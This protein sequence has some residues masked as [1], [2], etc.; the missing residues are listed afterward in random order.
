MKKIVLLILSMVMSISLTSCSGGFGDL[1]DSLLN[2]N[3]LSYRLSDDGEGYIVTGIGDYKGEDIVIPE[4]Y[5]NLPVIAIGK[6]VGFLLNSYTASIENNPSVYNFSN[7]H[8][9]L[10]EYSIVNTNAENGFTHNH[11]IRSIKIPKTIKNIS[12][13]AFACCT[14]LAYIEVDEDNSAYK[15]I[16]GNL[17][18]KDGKTLVQYALGKNEKNFAIPEGV[19]NISNF[20]F[21]S[22]ADNSEYLTHTLG[23]M[24]TFE[25]DSYSYYSSFISGSLLVSSPIAFVNNCK[26]TSYTSPLESVNIPG[27][28]K[29]I[30]VQAFYNCANLL[31]VTIPNGV[32]TIGENAFSSCK[33]LESV[34]IPESVTT[35]EDTAFRFCTSLSTFEVADGNATYKSIDGNLYSKDGKTLISYTIG[36]SD[37]TFNVPKDVT[38]I[39]S[40]AFRNALNLEKIIIPDTVEKIESNAF[41]G[42]KNLT[43]NEY[44]NGKYLGDETNPYLVLVSL[45]SLLVVNNITIN[46]NTKII[47][48]NSINIHN[49]DCITIPD[50]VTYIGKNAFINKSLTSIVLPSS[51]KFIEENHFYNKDCKIHFKGT[52][53]EWKTISSGI[54]EKFL[55]YIEKEEY[56]EVYYYS[57]TTPTNQGNYWHYDINGNIVVW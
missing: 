4:K 5:K 25:I 2:R 28:V 17:Y 50:N 45:D 42:C 29:T 37:K 24:A 15:S 6:T 40:Y 20:A 33:K 49:I 26:Q 36:K 38:T 53:T 7:L 12:E 54:D 9:S 43:Y 19:E 27:T 13:V 30:G 47:C 14:S 8:S 18:T 1:I 11:N 10:D 55:A 56:I 57:E 46:S 23:G 22:C 32:T 39:A 44:E 35:I 34:S 21:H 52:Y 16:D 31:N 51:I 48:S 3:Q 41:F